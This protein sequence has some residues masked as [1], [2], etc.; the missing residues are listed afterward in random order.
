MNKQNPHFMDR[1]LF[2]QIFSE[3]EAVYLLRAML[4]NKNMANIFKKHCFGIA[5][6]EYQDFFCGFLVSKNHPSLTRNIHSDQE[7]KRITGLRDKYIKRIRSY[8][9]DV[10]TTLLNYGLSSYAAI[11]YVHESTRILVNENNQIIIP[12][13]LSYEEW[14]QVAKQT[15]PEEFAAASSTRKR[16]EITFNTIRHSIGIYDEAWLE[17]PESCYG[18]ICRQFVQTIRRCLP[19][20]INVAQ[21]WLE[22]KAMTKNVDKFELDPEYLQLSDKFMRSTAEGANKLS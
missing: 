18:H 19:E 21:S 6:E 22:F 15:H 1:C 16:Q 8:E 10:S 5:F 12:V 14:V 9:K 13:V 4:K 2:V 3:D 11:P 7:L 20:L 17:L